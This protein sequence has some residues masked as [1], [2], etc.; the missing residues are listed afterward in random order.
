MSSSS[1][2]AE[3]RWKPSSEYKSISFF[4]FSSRRRHT[5]CQSVTGVQTCALPIS[6]RRPRTPPSPCG[7]RRH[8]SSGSARRR[9]AIRP[10]RGGA[11]RARGATRTRARRARAPRRAP[12]ARSAGGGA[13]PGR[14]ARR[15]CPRGRGRGAARGSR[16]GG[17][18]SA[19][20][21]RRPH[22]NCSR[23]SIMRRLAV[24]ALLAAGCPTPAIY[25]EIRP[26]LSCERAT[27]VTYRT[28][29]AL[30]YTV[31]ELVPATP[32][33]RG[34]VSGTKPGPEGSTL[35]GR[36]V[37][38][39]DAEGAVVKPVEDSVVPNYDFSRGFGYSFK[40]LVKHPDVEEPW[41]GRGLEVLVHALSPQEATLDLG[42]VATLGGA[43]PVRVTVRNNTARAI[44]LDPARI[45]LVPVG[46][47]GSGPLTG[48]ALARA[49]A[50][51]AAG[52]RAR[53]EPLLPGRVAAH[54]TASGYLVYPPGTYREARISI[55]DV[56][57]GESEGFVTP[58]E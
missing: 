47:T 36:V 6:W 34:V 17:A 13:R 28:L 45:E 32:E 50:P 15:R 55:E 33:R 29:V 8:G 39:C 49:L 41:D 10:R 16:R 3:G 24:L 1:G 46:G 44:A 27:R 25:K 11:R 38:T 42:G 48:E 5:R 7:R 26:G 56:E 30:G 58:V 57:T 12:R 20:P 53:A 51:G 14:S 9:A 43:V 22:E 31:T 35:T 40:E 52:D 2:W 4:F 19:R 23:K 21:C 18:W 54:T 37:I